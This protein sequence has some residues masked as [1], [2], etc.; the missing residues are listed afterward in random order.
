MIETYFTEIP[1]LE[2]KH[3]LLRGITIDDSS[4]LFSILGNKE[5]MTYITSN[6]VKS[7]EE[8][9]ELISTYLSSFLEKKE[10]PWVIIEKKTGLVVGQFRLHKLHIWH[11][12]AE[13]GAVIREE[14]QRKGVMSEV[15]Q[16]LLPFVF[17]TIK[18]NRLV[19]DIFAENEGSRKL[20]E[21]Y[22]FTKEGILR[23]TDFD[24]ERFHDTVVYS[25]LRRE[26]LE[27]KSSMN[28]SCSNL[29]N[30]WKN[31]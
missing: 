8:V 17:E 1:T 9:R 18:L 12:K 16:S 7:I 4:E 3:Y 27:K 10:I 14:F 30:S 23:N 15:L 5:T 20:L 24:G 6:P 29:H 19:G 21:K 31:I 22:S 26:Y 11:Q 2:T 28:L 13:M 25:M